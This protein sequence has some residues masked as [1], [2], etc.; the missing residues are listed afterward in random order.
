MSKFQILSVLFALFMMYAVGI[1]SKKKTLDAT[2][3]SLWYSVWVLFIVVAVF[4]GLVTGIAMTLR[5]T[6]VFDFLVVVAFMILSIVTFNNYYAS[7]KLNNKLEEMVRRQ[8]IQR[9]KKA[10]AK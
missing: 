5:F 2:E 3:T 10:I 4:P 7:K 8:T 9:N 1:H 6:R